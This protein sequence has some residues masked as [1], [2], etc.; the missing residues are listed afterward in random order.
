MDVLIVCLV[1]RLIGVLVLGWRW[2]FR[3][4]VVIGMIGY[5]CLIWFGCILN[6]I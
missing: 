4:L 6:M 1:C 3:V 2:L 5:L